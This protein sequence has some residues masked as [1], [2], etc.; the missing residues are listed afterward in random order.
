MDRPARQRLANPRDTR[1]FLRFNYLGSVSHDASRH[2]GRR[3]VGSWKV[4]IET[5]IRTGYLHRVHDQSRCCGVAA[6]PFEELSVVLVS[7]VEPGV[8]IYES[9]EEEQSGR[10]TC[11]LHVE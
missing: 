10:S 4:S 1:C 5:K 6:H 11:E 9:C 7:T 8:T 2:R 3:S